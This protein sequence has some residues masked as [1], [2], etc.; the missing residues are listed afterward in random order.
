MYEL[1]LECGNSKAL[2]LAMGWGVDGV[3]VDLRKEPYKKAIGKKFLNRLIKNSPLKFVVEPLL[4]ALLDPK[5]HDLVI[6][7]A[8][9]HG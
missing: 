8:R 6:G 3:N 2:L 9:L 4:P 1:Y 5:Y 7:Q